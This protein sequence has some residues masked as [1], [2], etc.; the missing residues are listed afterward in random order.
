MT[1]PTT[2][3]DLTEQLE[4]SLAAAIHENGE[5]RAALGR[6]REYAANLHADAERNMDEL[7]REASARLPGAPVSDDVFHTHLCAAVYG[8]AAGIGEQILKILDGKADR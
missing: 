1:D 4:T 6:I 2:P 5:L 3:E 8:A 7:R